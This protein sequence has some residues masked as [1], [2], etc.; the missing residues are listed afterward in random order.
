M[1]WKDRKKF[2]S[3]I[4]TATF[5]ALTA[6]LSHADSSAAKARELY[7]DGVTDY[8]LGH[9]DEALVAFESAY[10]AHRDAAFLFNIGQCQ[11]N[12]HKYEDAERSYR[13]FLRESSNLSDDSKTQI[14]KLIAEMDVAIQEQRAK[15]PPTGIQPPTGVEQ[16][17]TPSLSSAARNGTSGTSRSQSKENE[18]VAQSPRR[19]K[20][21]YKKAWFWAVLGTGAIVVA[22][23]ISLGVVFGSSQNQLLVSFR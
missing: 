15:Q 3:L 19:A 9:Y 8:N 12:L 20:P 11:R 2:L 6:P 1:H 10:R 17:S 18:L 22:G 23:A 4:L 13:A 21:I 5:L 7:D 16:P 14:Q